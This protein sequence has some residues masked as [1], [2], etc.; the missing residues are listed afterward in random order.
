M[1]GD[2]I[3]YRN[4]IVLLMMAG[5]IGTIS[6]TLAAPQV[7]ASG[8]DLSAVHAPLLLIAL[9]WI[10]PLT[11]QLGMNPN[12]SVSIR[13]PMLPEAAAHGV[14]PAVVVTAITSTWAMTAA[15]SPFTPTTLMVGTYLRHVRH[16]V[17]G[18]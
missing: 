11:R 16:D 3:G 9:V 1:T 17:T 7:A 18:S 13:A 4:E 2:L 14:S 5:F 10:V 12:L 15:S 6:A 8:L